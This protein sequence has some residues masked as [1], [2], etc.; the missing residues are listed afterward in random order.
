MPKIETGV[1]T[2]KIEYIC[3]HCKKG[4]MVPTGK[5]LPSY[6]PKYE[7]KCDN[8][9]CNAIENFNITYPTIEFRQTYFNNIFR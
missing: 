8:T 1:T 2:F 6:P 4:H 9:N 3:D 7:H 5:I